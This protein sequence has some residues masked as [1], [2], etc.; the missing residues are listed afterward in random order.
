MVARRPIAALATAL[1][2][3]TGTAQAGAVEEAHEM[4][5]SWAP[6]EIT[7]HRD[8]TLRIILPQRQI[9]SQIYVAALSTGICMGHL[10]DM[11]LPGVRKIAFLNE[12][13]R[14]GYVFERGTDGCEEIREAKDNRDRELRIMAYTHMHMN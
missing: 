12:F 11:H 6:T 13:G 7:L 10:F 5:W 14:Q 8:G 3:C 2:L 1:T 4:L 9:T